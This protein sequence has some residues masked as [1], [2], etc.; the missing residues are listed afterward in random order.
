[1][2]V[3]TSNAYSGPYTANGSTTT[4]PFTFSVM[5][6]SDV[7]VFL[8]DAD[9]IETVVDTADYTV[10]LTGSVPSSGSVIF[11]SAPASGNQ[12][13]VCLEPAFD[14]P[15]TFADGSAWKAKA[16]NNVNDRAA[17]RDQALKR[18]SARAFKVPLDEDPLP[19]ASLANSDGKVLGVVAGRITPVANDPT[20]A[21]DSAAAALAA[22][23]T[24]LAAKDETLAAKISVD[25]SR[26]IVETAAELAQD[27]GGAPVYASWAALNAVTGGSVAVIPIGSGTHTDPVV[28]GTVEDQ[29]VYAWSASPAGWQ[30]IGDTSEVRARQQVALA[31][32]AVSASAANA[33]QGRLRVDDAITYTSISPAAAWNGTAGTG[34]SV[35]PTDP[36]R[37]TAKPALRLIVPPNQ[38]FTDYLVVGVSAWA[39]NNG[40]FDNCG[41]QNVKFYYEGSTVTVTRPSFYSFPDAN[42]NTVTY[43]GWWCVLLHNGTNGDANLYVEATP[44]DTT[45]QNRVMGP[46]LFLPSATLYDLDLEVAPSQSVIAG[47]RYQSLTAALSYC[48]NQGKHHPRI[49]ITEA[50]TDYVIG[51]IS[52]PSFYTAGKGY[53]TI[54]ATVPVTIIGTTTYADATFRPKYSGLRFKGSNITFDFANADRLFHEGTGNQYWWDGVRIRSSTGRGYLFSSLGGPKPVGFSGGQPWITECV[55]SDLPI[56]ALRVNLARGST[57]TSSYSDAIGE[58]L[59][60]INCRFDDFDP[61]IDWSI[62][63]NAFT[64]TY[65]GAGTTATL[66]LSGGNNASSRTFNAKVDGVSVGTFTTDRFYTVGN[67]R[68]S[69]VVNWLNSLSGWSAT[70]QDDTRRASVLSVVGGT[71][72]AFSARNCKN[73]TLQLVTYFDYHGDFYQQNSPAT[74]TTENV[75][76]AH[77][78]VTNFAGQCFFIS[79]SSVARDFIF[80]NNCFHGKAAFGAYYNPGNFF[81]QIDR[82]GAKSHLVFAHNS[83]TQGFYIRTTGGWTADTYCLFADN[84][85]RT[86]EWLTTP[87]ANMRLADNH[88]FGGATTPSGSTNTTTGGTDT[89]LFQSVSTG[90]FT[91]KGAL[92][93]NLK[94][95]AI[96][97][98]LQGR[99]RARMEAPGASV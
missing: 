28:G 65:T 62:D 75:I 9:G 4:F 49:R 78:V 53:C 50:R 66:E 7:E 36:T 27:Y 87:N 90:D 55:V 1:M 13:L 77:N 96:R 92:L 71:G 57:F 99:V 46:Y 35:T 22:K 74:S 42:G 14:Q 58:A 39:N 3:S 33:L 84:V 21:A 73:V 95:P 79:S 80:I 88:L 23:E 30:R 63:V 8:R 5:T 94:V 25:S 2:A 76:V 81:S 34:F 19:V 67:G 93:T 54:E 98:D 83:S 41:L 97:R 29:G 43:F 11:D 64:V 45:M 44:K 18:D 51:T 70:L 37:T 61:Y 89:D 38:A 40:S 26:E 72:V 31:Q 60:V 6:T 85:F 91:P 24:T 56:P 12:V 69:S 15:A 86:L 17:L 59:C 10:A 52:S 16:V 48:A 68:N 47:S 32:A 82:S 20:S